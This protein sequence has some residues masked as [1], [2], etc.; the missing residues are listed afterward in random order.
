MKLAPIKPYRFHKNTLLASPMYTHDTIVKIR[1][2]VNEQYEKKVYDEFELVKAQKKIFKDQKFKKYGMKF[3]E[4]NFIYDEVISKFWDNHYYHLGDIL[5]EIPELFDVFDNYV[6]KHFPVANLQFLI[7]IND[8]YWNVNH[9]QFN[10]SVAVQQAKN[11]Y[12]T[13]IS[14]RSTQQI[15]LPMNVVTKISNEMKTIKKFKDPLSIY[16]VAHDI[17]LNLIHKRY[18]PNFYL[19]KEFLNYYE[20]QRETH[21]H[22]NEKRL[23]KRRTNSKPFK[24]PERIENKLNVVDKF[25]QSAYEVQSVNIAPAI[26]RKFK[27]YFVF[28]D[29]K[30]K[31]WQDEFGTIYKCYNAD[32][33]DDD[34][35]HDDYKHEPSITF[36][37]MISK[38]HSVYPARGQF[39][40]FD[41]DLFAEFQQ[42]IFIVKKINKSKFHHLIEMPNILK[43]Q[44]NIL[45]Q[46]KEINE[47]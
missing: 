28:D 26:E 42:E 15:N 46:L 13:F 31:L 16:N 21:E 33:K 8:A 7:Q 20:K 23:G 5:F 27:D 22:A 25:E 4:S 9:V 1:E 10:H 41:Q 35:N 43:S 18:L 17:I 11:I 47:R 32:V 44:V 29:D 3:D 38:T 36:Q 14:A 34:E 2:Y 30:D 37:T 6:T 24:A 45:E 40:A 12:Q 19:S 39:A